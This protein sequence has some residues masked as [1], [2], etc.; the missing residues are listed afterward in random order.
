[1]PHF[2]ASFATFFIK[3]DQLNLEVTCF[4]RL[5][6]LFTVVAFIPIRL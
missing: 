4:L 1:M 2:F 3:V 5:L 6:M